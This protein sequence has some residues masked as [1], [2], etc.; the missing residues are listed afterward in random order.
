MLF[1]SADRLG[2]HRLELPSHLHHV[3]SVEQ[4]ET[5]V[6]VDPESG[7][8]TVPVV[9]VSEDGH[10]RRPRDQVLHAAPED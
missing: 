3:M 4:S 1:Q 10:F 5:E 9:V 8:I 2:W 6:G 7:A